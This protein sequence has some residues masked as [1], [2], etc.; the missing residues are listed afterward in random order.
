MTLDRGGLLW[1]TWF[2]CRIARTRVKYPS[3]RH[4]VEFDVITMPPCGERCKNPAP[5]EPGGEEQ[6]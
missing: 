5:V 2:G 4:A 6:P 3:R 1:A